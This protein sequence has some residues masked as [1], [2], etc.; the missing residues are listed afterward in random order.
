MKYSPH[1]RH[2]QVKQVAG[3]CGSSKHQVH[4]GGSPSYQRCTG[5]HGNERGVRRI[6]GERMKWLTKAEK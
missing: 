1:S 3:E 4:P 6:E 5:Q 2:T